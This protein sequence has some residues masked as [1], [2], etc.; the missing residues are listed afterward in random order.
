MKA[1]FP[2]FG[3][4]R[5]VAAEVWRRFGDVKNYVEPFAGSLAVLLARP[6]GA[7]PIETVNDADGLLANFWR[8]MVHDPKGVAHYAD[9]PVNEADLHARHWWLVEQREDLTAR[10]MGDPDWYDV[11]AAGWWVWGAC[12]WIGRDW[13]SGKGPWVSMNGELVDSRELEMDV[14]AGISRQIP[15]LG[16]A[17]RGVNRQ[18]QHLG[19]AGQGIN[20]RRDHSAGVS[21]GV[22]QHLMPVAE[23]IKNVR[24]TCG[25]WLRVVKSKSSTCGLGLTGVFLDPPYPRGGVDYAVGEAREVYQDVQ[26]WA[27]ERGDS[28]LMRIAVCGYAGDHD[29]LEAAGWSV[30]A[31]KA[32]GGYGV[33]SKGAA[34]KN[35][36]LER[37]WFS[38]HCLPPAE[39]GVL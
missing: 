28:P 26:A 31:W 25:D 11:K 39:Q 13:C 8:A 17:G 30:C 9:W 16:D 6:G 19:N 27:L 1:P 23:R 35:S 10:L 21:R 36:A 12:A 22:D 18:I 7:G 38:P 29:A 24:V 33:Q 32:N 15:H 2:Y 3:G 5:S 14:D 37:V 34:R 4:K 20:R